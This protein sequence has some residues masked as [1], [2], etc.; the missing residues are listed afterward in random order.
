MSTAR[1]DQGRGVIW[2][3]G[4]LDRIGV[5]LLWDSILALQGQGHR[6]ID[7]RLRPGATMCADA[8]G[9]FSDLTRRLRA[10]G[11]QLGPP[12]DPGADPVSRPTVER[13]AAG[14]TGPDPAS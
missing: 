1:V 5:E 13:P 7:V 4:H 14:Q 3:R 12:P 6:R 10:D 2:I 11:V 9:S 8:G